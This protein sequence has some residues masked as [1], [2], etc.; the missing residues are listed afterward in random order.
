MPRNLELKA[1]L[2]DIAAARTIAV[3]LATETL[4]VQRQVDTYFH[5]PHGRLKL[6]EIDGQRAQLVWYARDN[7]TDVRPSDYVLA[8]VDDGA[9]LHLALT[10]ALGVRGTV[11][12]R[13]EIFLYHNVRIHLDEVVNLGSFLEFEAVLGPTA[14][15]SVSRTRLAHLNGAFDLSPS[16]LLSGSYSDMLRL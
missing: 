16:D 6:R 10:Q 4:G 7:H 13:R 3:G 8:P 5:C 12:K 2:A 9:A 11:E 14:D 15:E 1:R